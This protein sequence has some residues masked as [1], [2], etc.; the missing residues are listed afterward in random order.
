MKLLRGNGK[1]KEGWVVVFIGEEW[2]F[3]PPRHLELEANTYL[4]MHLQVKPLADPDVLPLEIFSSER[5]S[6]HNAMNITLSNNLVLNIRN[7][8][9]HERNSTTFKQKD[10]IPSL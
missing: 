4:G 5:L 8:S 7:M 2:Q 6:M 9:Q 10:T 1:A 3:Q